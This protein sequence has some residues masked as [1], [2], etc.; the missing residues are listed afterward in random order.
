M[1]TI[2][3]AMIAFAAG[4]A[5]ALS[6]AI[7]TFADDITETPL[8]EEKVL[9]EETPM[10]VVEE[11]I[12]E[13][14]VEQFAVARVQKNPPQPER[15]AICHSGSGKN[16]TF[17]APDANGYNGHKNHDADVYG[18]TEGECLA[19]NFTPYGDSALWLL[20]ESWPADQT[21]VPGPAIYDQTRIWSGD[22]AEIPCERWGQLDQY[23]FENQSEVDLYNS[24]G[25]VLTQGEDYAIYKSHIF[26]YG[27]VCEEPTPDPVVCSS[28]SDWYTELDDVA[29]VLTIDGLKFNGQTKAVGYRHL[30]NGNLQGFTSASFSATNVGADFYF[31]LT[32]DLSADGGPAYKSLSFPGV[33]TI[34]Q[35]SVPYQFPGKTLADLAVEYP[36]NVLTSA[37][38]QTSTNS[39]GTA[40]L[41]SYLSDCGEGSW[42]ISHPEDEF[43]TDTWTNNPTCVTPLDGTA[44][45][46]TWGQDWTRTSSPNED[47]TAWVFGDKVP[48]GEP[49]LI[50]SEIVDSEEC[51]VP[52]TE[53]PEEP[54]EDPTP[55]TPTKVVPQLPFT[56]ADETG[57]WLGASFAVALLLTGTIITVMMTR[58]QYE[59]Q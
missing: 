14:E 44:T 39:G 11:V 7:G 22:V 21:P 51:V 27:G 13:P 59:E 9:V 4:G 54:T 1:R 56:G 15:L 33:T 24:L 35:D 8:P 40:V 31:R 2:R 58:R 23:W 49:Y 16:W 10:P 19:K 29:P 57:L 34:T 32:V 17:I 26:V 55:I 52:P 25:D 38:F 41:H 42:G 47:R 37:G 18:L 46:E 5:L 6:P 43:G 50:D 28:T 53:E 12:P 36:N 20:P 48:V 3:K 45:I 30:I